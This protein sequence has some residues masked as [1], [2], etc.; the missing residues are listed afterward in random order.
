[1]LRWSILLFLPLLVCSQTIWDAIN[2]PTTMGDFGISDVV[3]VLNDPLYSAIKGVLMNNSVMQTFF[4]PTDDAFGELNWNKT[5]PANVAMTSALLMY[6][7]TWGALNDSFLATAELTFQHTMLNDPTLVSLGGAYQSIAIMYDGVEMMG[8]LNDEAM[9][10]NTFM[11]MGTNGFFYVTDMVPTIPT[12]T[13]DTTMS[14]SSTTTFA[15]TIAATNLSWTA[16]DMPMLTI[17]V[18][19]N[20]AFQQSTLIDN[21]FVVLKGHM[22]PGVVWS[23]QLMN[24]MTLPTLNITEVTGLP[25][26]YLQITSDSMG[27]WWVNGYAKIIMKDIIT[28]NGVVHVVD[29]VLWA[30]SPRL[31]IGQNIANSI[32]TLGYVAQAI[33]P[34]NA[35]TA[36]AMLFMPPPVE[37][38]FFAPTNN[39]FLAAIQQNS[40]LPTIPGIYNATV[41]YLTLM[42]AWRSD[43]FGAYNITDTMSNNS[44]PNFVNLAPAN[45]FQK[46][47]IMNSGMSFTINNGET[48][49]ASFTGTVLMK[50]IA[51]LNGVLQVV[52]TLVLTPMP[53][54]QVLNST[55]FTTFIS[56]AVKAQVIPTLDSTAGIVIFAP[57]NAA[58]S[59]ASLSGWNEK[60]VIQGHI[61]TS[62]LAYSDDWMPGMSYTLTTAY[63]SAKLNVSVDA[64]GTIWV[65]DVKGTKAK[66]ISSD[67]LVK[68]GVVHVIDH[69]LFPAASPNS[70]VTSSVNFL[71]L[72]SLLVVLLNNLF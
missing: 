38:T 66:V 52:D 55:N 65:Y 12:N 35:G 19:N 26:R 67:F 50:D 71:V 58:F 51:C 64:T 21:A 57:T 20:A 32:A 16:D 36:G 53:P 15:A 70:G 31:P 30:A 56:D 14:M 8:T 28:A 60:S 42:G 4:I 10:N 62:G 49:V 44:Y 33:N 63:P 37:L 29:D 1:M 27:N 23:T 13:T 59:A 40:S 39:G 43:A 24:N 11:G 46:L 25:P 18:P 17:F 68:N 3:N 69:V 6:G 54:S 5:D 2:D 7:M 34:A 9:F 48:G 47:K 45:A 41:S 72:A 22:V 61:V